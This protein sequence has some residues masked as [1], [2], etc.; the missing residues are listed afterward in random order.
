MISIHN[1]ENELAQKPELIQKLGI[2]QFIYQGKDGDTL[3][4]CQY[5]HGADKPGKFILVCYFHGAGSRGN[6]NFLQVRIGAPPLAS[7]CER[8]GL[9]VLVIMPQCR[10][11]CKWVDVPWESESHTLPPEPSRHMKLALALLDA[12]L[13]EFDIDRERIYALGMSMGGYAVFD[14]LSRRP[15]LFAAAASMCGGGDTAQAPNLRDT[16][17]YLIHGNEDSAVPVVRSR[18]MAKALRDAGNPN[19]VYHELAGVDHNVWD[20]FFADDEGLDFLF[21]QKR[22][23]R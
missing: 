14:M 15:E 2:G 19:V 5:M 7:Y 18:N 22:T 13:K 11:N 4:F 1:S 16:A 23:L 17:F 9:K 10:E 20:P 12:K 6:D 21:A 8:H 3:P